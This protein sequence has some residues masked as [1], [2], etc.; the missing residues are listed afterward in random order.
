MGQ[1]KCGGPTR[2]S[3]RLRFSILNPTRVALERLAKE[4]GYF[5]GRKRLPDVGR[6]ID[7]VVNQSG[8]AQVAKEPEYLRL[9]REAGLATV[10]KL[11]DEQGGAEGR[12][13]KCSSRY[14]Q[15][16]LKHGR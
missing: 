8:I 15:T 4:R 13:V 11:D 2:N 14:L 3:C 10:P 5:T 1:G 16:L 12:S 7:E 6:V 9:A